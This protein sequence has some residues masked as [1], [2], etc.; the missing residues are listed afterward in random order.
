MSKFASHT[1]DAAIEAQFP[2]DIAEWIRERVERSIGRVIGADLE[3][4]VEDIDEIVDGL[5]AEEYDNLSTE[6][7]QL[8]DGAMAEEV[9]ERLKGV[10]RPIVS[11]LLRN[12][13]SQ[14]AA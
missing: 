13:C 10:A 12:M 11:T 6:Y 1:V 2:H 4:S 14:A 8:L 5:V 7:Q 9:V 3:I